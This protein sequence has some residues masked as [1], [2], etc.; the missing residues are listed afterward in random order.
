MLTF[1][2]RNGV[3]CAEGLID[4]IGQK[5]YVYQVDGMLIDSGPES[6][7]DGLV[8]FFQQHSFDQLVLTHYHEDHT[9]NAAWIQD[10]LAIPIFVH[11]NGLSLCRADGDYPDYRRITWGGR[12]AFSP[13]LLDKQVHSRTLLWQ[14]IHT[15]GHA[16]DHVAFYNEANKLMFTGDLFLSAK[17]KVSMK[18]ESIP[19]IMQ[20]IRLLLHYDFTSIFCSHAGYLENGRELLM[21]KL[22]YL[23][24]LGVKARELAASGKS[25]REIA[26]LLLPVSYPIIDFSQREWDTVHL[27]RSILDEHPGVNGKSD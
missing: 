8:P 9:G 17:T 11:P 22:I 12:P 2:E 6:L 23:E 19:Q 24:D 1:Y 4:A 15:P 25:S 21:Q 26:D 10:N 13:Q 7:Q 14:V 16:A 27:I 3:Q 18:T 20:S 5:V